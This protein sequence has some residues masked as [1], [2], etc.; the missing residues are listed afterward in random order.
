[1]T[2]KG[3]GLFETLD[4]P[5][6]GLPKLRERIGGA[7]RW[8]KRRRPALG[9]AAVALLIV[10]VGW[11][12]FVPSKEPNIPPELDLVRMY[13]GQLPPPSEALTIPKDRRGEFSVRRVP[14]PTDQVIF[15]LVGSSQ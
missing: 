11:V 6:G 4:P 9:A 10:L 8:R 15:Y 14:L 12:V 3:E 7:A 5:P 1:M 2:T 13:L